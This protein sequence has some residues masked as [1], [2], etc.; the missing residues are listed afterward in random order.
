MK[1]KNSVIAITGGGGG[2]GFAMAKRFAQSGAKLALLD[3]NAELL[4]AAEKMLAPFA[5][6]VKSYTVDIADETQVE[7]AFKSIAD[8]FG[9][10]NG[11][12]NNAGIIRDGLLVKVEDG[13]V[14]KKM[15]LGNWQAVINVNLTGVFLC[16][17]EA[18]SIMAVGH[19]P[20]CIINISSIA[21]KGNMGQ[22]NYSATKAGVLAMT[23]TWAKELG[24]YGIRCAAIAPGFVST[25]ILEGMKQTALEKLIKRVPLE[26]LAQPEE[27]AQ[28]AEFIFENDYFTGRVLELDGGLRI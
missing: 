14:V 17:R 9:Q 19:Q 2:L 15:S 13:A 11:L 7:T 3:H 8:D 22:T 18:A 21:A 25:P 1:I 26:R 6:S 10:L 27:V 24:K 4:A 28:A 5:V 23:V 16:G 20:G 12:V